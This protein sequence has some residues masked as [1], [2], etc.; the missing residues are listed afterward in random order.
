MK[1]QISAKIKKTSW[2]RLF[3]G[4]MLLIGFIFGIGPAIS[5][6]IQPTFYETLNASGIRA[7]GLFYTDTQICAT[8]EQYVIDS[9]RF[10]P[11]H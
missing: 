9:L 7:N 11:A 10:S 1:D 6:R 4:V 2:I 5:K 3:L 8:A